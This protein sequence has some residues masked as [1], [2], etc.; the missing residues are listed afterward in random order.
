M[1]SLLEPPENRLFPDDSP[2]DIRETLLLGRAV[3]S[4]FQ[5]RVTESHVAKLAGIVE[6]VIP[7][8]FHPRQPARLE[9]TQR[10]KVRSLRARD[11][12]DLHA[13]GLAAAQAL[14]NFPD[15]VLLIRDDDRRRQT[16]V[17]YLVE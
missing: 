4:A 10:G 15:G 2:P 7:L 9:S 12:G 16:E 3:E 11:D 6:L 13:Q 8:Y 14:L 1:D 17:G 5:T